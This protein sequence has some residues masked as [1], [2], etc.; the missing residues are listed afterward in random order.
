MTKKKKKCSVQKPLYHYFIMLA[1]KLT[2]RLLPRMLESG[3]LRREG[4]QWGGERQRGIVGS[5]AELRG[6][7]AKG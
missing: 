7:R 4:Q 1:L 6:P 5:P 2:K 3:R